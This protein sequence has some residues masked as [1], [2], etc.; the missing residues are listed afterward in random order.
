MGS[1]LA[2]LPP[3]PNFWYHA[4]PRRLN[5]SSR[6]PERMCVQVTQGTESGQT[7]LFE[8]RKVSYRVPRHYDLF[9]LDEVDFE[10]DAGEFVLLLGPNGSGK[11]TV[12]KLLVG[13]E[14]LQ[15]G[16][17]Y[18]KGERIR[19][20]D[21]LT[22]C[23]IVLQDPSKYFITQRVIDELTIGREER[24]PEDVRRVLTDVGLTDISL[25]S[26]PCALSGGQVRRLAVADQMLKIPSPT[27][28]I[29]DEP[30]SGVDWVGRRDILKFLTE[31]KH[32]RRMSMLL[33]SHEPADLL[34]FADRVVELRDRKL[35]P[36][37]RAIIERAIETRKDLKKKRYL[38]ALENARQYKLSL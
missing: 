4:D 19:P 22:L 8:M 31:L 2:F 28:F 6:R 12:V 13:L 24:T 30:L 29:L 7:P 20:K 16:E 37:D 27:L 1:A 25:M 5:V 17:V 26:D 32:Q 14:K 18:W 15:S 3:T 21:M 36:V 34:P 33:V 9:L 10:I 35:I 38:E 11:S 23:G